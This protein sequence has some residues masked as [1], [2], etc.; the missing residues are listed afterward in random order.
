MKGF[1]RS[2]AKHGSALAFWRRS[3]AEHTFEVDGGKRYGFERE[4]IFWALMG[5]LDKSMNLTGFGIEANIP[6]PDIATVSFANQK[7]PS[8][9]LSTLS[10]SSNL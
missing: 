6:R 8:S 10:T 7:Y 3:W 5:D 2:P 4:G 1:M 9:L